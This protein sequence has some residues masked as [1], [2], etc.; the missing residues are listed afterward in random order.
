MKR[1]RL[2]LIFTVYLALAVTGAFTF[3]AAETLHY[4]ENKDNLFPGGLLC[5]VNHTADFPAE[6]TAAFNK[7]NRCSSSPLRSGWLRIFLPG[8][9]TT[10]TYL[11]GSSLQT[12]DEYY[13]P[14]LKNSILVN[15]RI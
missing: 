2:C 3:S 13:V 11:T 4:F 10:G 8:I 9:Q 15:L 6:N 1:K 14:I 5:S 12:T 7:L